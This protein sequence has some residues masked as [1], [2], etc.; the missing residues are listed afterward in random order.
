MRISRKRYRRWRT[1][2][3]NER[4]SIETDL[5]VRKAVDIII[6]NSKEDKTKKTVKADDG[7]DV[8]EKKI[9]KRK[10]KTEDTEE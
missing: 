6:E 3:D 1:A 7:D 2:T 10:K 5:K 8:I 4:K 9:P